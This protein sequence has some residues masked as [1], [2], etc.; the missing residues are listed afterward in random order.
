[1][2]KTMKI[3]ETKKIKR[4]LE[5]CSAASGVISAISTS[6]FISDIMNDENYD[7]YMTKGMFGLI[8]LGFSYLSTKVSNVIEENALENKIEK[9]FQKVKVK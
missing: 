6:S 5:L 7:T 9:P 4:M 2:E 1:M 3:E 8:F